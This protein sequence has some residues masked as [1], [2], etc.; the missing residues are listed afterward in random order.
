MPRLLPSS[1]PSC[2]TASRLSLPNSKKWRALVGVGVGTAVSVE[3]GEVDEEVDEEAG[4]ADMGEVVE[5][6]VVGI[7]VV[8]VVVVGAGM[9]VIA[10][11]NPLSTL[12]C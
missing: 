10:D 6:G 5:V 3:G 4:E 8:V 12:C 9:A 7:L 1:W 11:G 2:K